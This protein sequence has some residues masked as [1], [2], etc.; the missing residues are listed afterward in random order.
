MWP[1]TLA[2]CPHKYRAGFP[3]SLQL[4]GIIYN[5][6]TIIIHLVAQYDAALKDLYQINENKIYIHQE[7]F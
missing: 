5:F 6:R 7:T 4:Q 2:I 3:Q 1:G